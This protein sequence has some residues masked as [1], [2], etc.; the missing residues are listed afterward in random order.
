MGGLSPLVAAAE[1]RAAG[2]LA[3]AFAAVRSRLAVVAVLLAVAGVS[4]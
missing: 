1:P 2:S 3:P 4:S